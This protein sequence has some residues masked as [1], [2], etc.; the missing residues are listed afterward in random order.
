M[1]R[2][3]S[4]PILPWPV[5]AL[6]V[7]AAAA[8]VVVALI[9]GGGGNGGN[10]GGS[11]TPAP[12]PTLPPITGTI[13]YITPDGN[14][15]L[16]DADGA[17][18]R[19]LTSDGLAKSFAWSPDGS[20]AALEVASGTAARVRGIRPD[21][22]VAFDIEGGSKPLWSSGGEELAVEVGNSVAVYD[23][24]GNALRVFESAT[25]PTWSPDGASVAFLKLGADGK[26]VPVI[27]ELSTGTE[28]PLAADI[29]PAD[30]VFPIAS[31]PS[32][33]IIA[34]RNRLYEPATGAT[35]DLPGTAV[36]WSP[37]GRTLL[38]AGEFVPAYRATPGL[39]LDAT[40]GLKQTIGLDI[41]PS[42]EDIPA[43][44]FIQK[45]TE[46]TPDGR[47]LLYMD[48]EPGR[49]RIR[50]YDTE[51]IRQDSR[52][53]IAGERPDISLNARVQVSDRRQD[54]PYEGLTVTFMHEGKVWVFPLD[55]RALVAVAE[56]GYPAWQPTP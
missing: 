13:G 3:D 33:G 17:N 37:N 45:W 44:L 2:P 6:G 56:G 27:G 25:L 8:A 15:A 30:P 18:Q 42:A 10:V 5:L 39:I 34:Y 24:S 4:K 40:Q 31:H 12:T 21:G 9:Y 38:A 29:E 14:F 46:W 43:Q 51:A 16:M 49:E 47:Y 22:S 48:P 32:G 55:G 50:I 19:V 1:R 35:T 53:N 23:A 52:R 7:A 26:A 54:D 11:P 36:Y 41:R 20:V 28:S